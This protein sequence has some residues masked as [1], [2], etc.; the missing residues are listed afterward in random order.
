M[1]WFV[2]LFSGAIRAPLSGM[3]DCSPR[4]AV[5][6]YSQKFSRPEKDSDYF[7][8]GASFRLSFPM[9]WTVLALHG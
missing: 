6:N 3:D 7:V 9:V 8:T 5:T 1:V 2:S 4:R